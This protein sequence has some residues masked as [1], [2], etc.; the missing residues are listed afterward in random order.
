[1]KSNVWLRLLLATV[2]L[3]GVDT[4][5]THAQQMPRTD[6]VEVPAIGEGLCVSNVFQSNMVLQRDKPIH[7]WGWAEPGEQVTVTFAGEQATAM[8]GK[9]RAW[10]VTLPAVSANSKPQPM[11]VKGNNTSIA[12]DNI[13]IGDVWVLGGQSNMEFPLANV[14]NGSLEIISA[15]FPEIRI[16]SVPHDKGPELKPGFARLHQWSD[17][18]GRHYRKGDWDVCTPGTVRELSAIGYVFARRVHKAAN[19]PIGVI[20]ASRGGSTVETWT[21]L[22][23]LRAMDSEPTR[24]KLAKWDADIASWDPQQD[25]ENRIASHLAYVERMSKEGKPIPNNRKEKPS[26]LRPG[27]IGNHNHP[28]HCYAGMIAPIAGLSVKG[29]IFHQ[30]YNNAFDGSAGADLYGD[31]FPEMIKAWRTAFGDPE[32]PFGILSLCT[33]GNPQTRDDYCEKMFNAGIEIR[34]A[35]YQTFLDFYN[36]GD[37]N[38]GFVS[39]YDLRRRWYHPQL[40]IPAGERIARW[41][42]ATQYGFDKQ[43]EWKPPMLL[44]ME[45]RN[46]ALLLKLDTDVSDPEDGAIE[47]FAIAGK[48]R[49]FHPADV[50][51]AEKGKNDRGQVQYDRKQLVLTSPMVTEPI[52]FRYAWGRNPLANLQAT[53]NKD[54][55]FA[56]QRSDNWRMEEVPL[57]V[58]GDEVTLPLS[59]GDQNKIIQ[60]LREQDKE[61]RLKEAEQVIEANG[62][63]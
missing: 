14:E 47:G 33:D 42:L 45:S 3:A 61:R 27:P 4:L 18:S 55:P 7:V 2:T 23:V 31:I 58:L 13:L 41:A 21:P 12:L 43:V 53:G 10:K 63:T 16:L 8:A 22:P 38:I 29:A 1:M 19:V 46:G 30:G 59:R 40:K 6:V 50:A 9:D 25:L 36:A 49:R 5:A 44:G 57:G 56:T 32:M 28:G 52:H 17:W 48:D 26:D 20:D 51:Y 39:T 35:Q 15:N 24:A 37:K 34:A 60:A 62:G 11:T 54:L